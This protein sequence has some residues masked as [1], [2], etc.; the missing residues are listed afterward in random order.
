MEVIQSRTEWQMN[1][2]EQIVFVNHGAKNNGLGTDPSSRPNPL[3]N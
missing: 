2:I 3:A 1:G